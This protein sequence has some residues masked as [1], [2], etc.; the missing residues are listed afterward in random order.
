MYPTDY[1]RNW[2][3]WRSKTKLEPSEWHCT[4]SRLDSDFH[5]GAT[6]GFML[7]ARSKWQCSLQYF[8]RQTKA[9]F[10]ALIRYTCET[11]SSAHQTDRL[12]V[13]A[14]IATRRRS[15]MRPLVARLRHPR[16]LVR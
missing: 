16:V 1:M 4:I 5:R 12:F 14:K 15:F 9:A 7:Q 8:E 6:D 10:G 3:P 11:V 2:K 13:S